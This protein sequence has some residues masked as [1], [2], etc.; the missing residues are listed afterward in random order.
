VVLSHAHYDHAG[1]L[2]HLPDVPVFAHRDEDLS[3]IDPARDIRR[4]GDSFD[5]FGDGSAE[6][7][8]T[9]GHTPGHQSLRVRR[10]GGYDVLAGDACYFCRSLTREDA[11]Q[12]HAAD[13]PAFIA[14]KRRLAQMQADGGFVIPGHD[15]AFLDAIPKASTVRPQAVSWD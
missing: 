12:P 13:K 6:L 1:G 9:P 8:A 14:S 10:F 4:T 2:S 7:F 3:P 5:L 15:E 11:D